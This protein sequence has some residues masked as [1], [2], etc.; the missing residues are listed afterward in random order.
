MEDLTTEPADAVRIVE[1]AGDPG[2]GIDFMKLE[3]AVA[4]PG[5]EPGPVV[6]LD[7]VAMELEPRAAEQRGGF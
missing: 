5:K 7:P 3:L 1:P 2:V 4:G 6:E